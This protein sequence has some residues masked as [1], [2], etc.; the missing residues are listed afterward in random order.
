MYC[1]SCRF[2]WIFG[3]RI[4]TSSF[5]IMHSWALREIWRK[6]ER[7]AGRKNERKAKQSHCWVKWSEMLKH[8]IYHLRYE[9]EIG[10]FP[11][12]YTLLMCGERNERIQLHKCITYCVLWD[13]YPFSLCLQKQKWATTI[14]LFCSHLILLLHLHADINFMSKAATHLLCDCC[15][16]Y[17]FSMLSWRWWCWWWANTHGTTKEPPR[18]IS[19]TYICE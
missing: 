8:W 18:P 5:I 3:S 15:C 17:F 14:S 4:T 12:R 6:K 10:F 1:I 19:Y 7:Q 13:K 16:C 9:Y 11:F 2:N